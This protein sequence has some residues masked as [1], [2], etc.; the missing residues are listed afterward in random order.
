MEPQRKVLRRRSR[1]CR[2]QSPGGSG[3][4]MGWNFRASEGNPPR[5]AGVSRLASP[6]PS[7]V[8]AAPPMV[9]GDSADKRND[10]TGEFGGGPSGGLDLCVVPALL[11]SSAFVPIPGGARGASG[12]PPPGLDQPSAF[13][14]A[15]HE[16][17]GE[18]VQREPSVGALPRSDDS[19]HHRSMQ[20]AVREVQSAS[21]L[22]VTPWRR[23]ARSFHRLSRRDGSAK[24]GHWDRFSGPRRYEKVARIPQDVQLTTCALCAYSPCPSGDARPQRIKESS[25]Q[26]LR[27]W[28]P[29]HTASLLD[30]QA[31]LEHH[32][33]LSPTRTCGPGHTSALHN[34][35]AKKRC[36]ILLSS[37]CM[38]ET[39]TCST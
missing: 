6:Q 27:R 33:R 14:R 37:V 21:A 13:P 3:S 17:Q 30:R 25:N 2:F 9:G 7:E 11:R 38:R 23:V 15:G 28:S 31:P 36:Q 35:V 10:T 34:N 20:S 18:C 39:L 26:S 12:G 4:R 29:S 16:L 1:A 24:R 19:V 5:R 8:E 32:V 22:P